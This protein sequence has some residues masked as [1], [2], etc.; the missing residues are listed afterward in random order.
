M[1]TAFAPGRINDGSFRRATRSLRDR[2]P[3]SPWCPASNHFSYC[4]TRP[5]GRADVTPVS[6]KPRRLAST[7]SSFAIVASSSG[8]LTCTQSRWFVSCALD[9]TDTSR[10]RTP[11]EVETYVTDAFFS[12]LPIQLLSR[13]LRDA[14]ARTQ[15]CC[16]TS[17]FAG[18]MHW[19]ESRDI[20][21]QRP[22]AS[23]MIFSCVQN[24]VSMSFAWTA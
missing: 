2:Y 3:N 10:A 21:L 12:P 16:P 15:L 6:P 5:A 7:F 17:P 24:D 18:A 1:T 4:S 8:Q 11:K 22:V 13:R 23:K 20:L 14:K 9:G 19:R